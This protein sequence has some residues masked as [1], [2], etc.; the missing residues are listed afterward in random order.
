MNNTTPF[1]DPIRTAYFRI[2]YNWAKSL[3]MQPRK[4]FF[5][6]RNKVLERYPINPSEQPLTTSPCQE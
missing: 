4:A 2:M 3:Q 5:I 6:A 1:S